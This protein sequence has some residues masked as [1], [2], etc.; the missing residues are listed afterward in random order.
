MLPSVRRVVATAPQSHLLSSLPRGATATTTTRTLTATQRR[1]Y[2]SSKPSRDNGSEDSPVR[3]SVQPSSETKT[4]EAKTTE[5]KTR[6]RKAKDTASKQQF[7]SVPTT[8]HIPTDFFA[9]SSFFS[10]H[11]PISVT[12]GLPRN[13]TEDAFSSIFTP[14]TRGQK[15]AEVMTTLSRT[16]QGLEQPMARISLQQ[17]SDVAENDRS[18]HQQHERA[19]MR[20]ADGSDV[21]VT[22]QINNMSGQFLPFRPPPVPQPESAVSE[23]AKSEADAV[24]E[25]ARQDMQTRVYKAVFTIEETTDSNGEV[26]IMAHTPEL[27]EE[28]DASS[29][30]A[31]E[32]VME[33]PGVPQTFIGRMALRQQQHDDALRSRRTMLAISVKRQ[34]RLKMKKKKYKKLTKRLRHERLKHGRT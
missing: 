13:I 24:E 22:L 27:I 17:S 6:K 7:P 30:A 10:L 16:V 26:R 33:E 20:N 11:R 12:C 15:A 19:G 21:S 25:N 8:A 3:Q 18:H 31:E 1:R 32:A 4:A 34:R 28:P 5:T 14:L 23:S 29:N 9:L 2:S